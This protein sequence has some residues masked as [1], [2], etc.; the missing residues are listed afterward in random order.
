MYYTLYTV[1]EGVYTHAT[2]CTST[3]DYLRTP[4]YTC[5]DRVDTL[6]TYTL[7]GTSTQVLRVV[8][9]HQTSGHQRLRSPLTYHCNP[10]WCSATATNS[11]LLLWLHLMLQH[12]PAFEDAL[13]E[14]DFPNLNVQVI[15][16]NQRMI[17]CPL[18][19]L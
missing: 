18:P 7:P 13:I 1:Y 3:S 14:H 12:R 9:K 10:L 11:A 17:F 6:T 19:M 4:S 15:Q 8:H 16:I 5:L 2:K